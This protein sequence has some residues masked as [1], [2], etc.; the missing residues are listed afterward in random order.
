[1][2]DNTA[3]NEIMR[4][5]VQDAEANYREQTWNDRPL[6]TL[7]DHFPNGAV[8]LFDPELRFLVAGGQGLAEAGLPPHFLEGKTVW[9]AFDPA[10]AA[11]NDPLMRA[12]LEGRASTSEVSY[13]ERVYEL[14]VL[15]IRNDEGVVV[16][17]MTLTQDITARKKDESQQRFLARAAELLTSSLDYQTTLQSVAQLVVPH[18]ADWCVVHLLNENGELEL[19]TAAHVDPARVE[20]ALASSRRY[21]PRMDQ[22]GG[23]AGVARTGQSAWHENITDDMFRAAAQDEEH[24]RLLA[25]SGMTSYLCVPLKARGKI[26]GTITF[27]GAESGHRYTQD[28]LPLAEELA[29]YAAVAVDNA[30]LFEQAQQQ[31][32]AREQAQNA[33]RDSEKQLRLVMD[34]APILISYIDLQQRYRFNNKTYADWLKQSP[35]LINGKHV[36]DVIGQAAYEAVREQ[37]EAALRGEPVVY[38]REMRYQGVMPRYVH[39]EFVPDRN[40]RGDVQGF[41]AVVSDI[42]DIKR[43][44]DALAES[45]RRYRFMADSIPQIVWTASAD[46]GVDYYNQR[47]TEYTGLTLAQTGDW[48]WRACQHPDDLQPTLNAWARAL[49]TGVEYKIEHRVRGKD[50]KYHWFLTRGV[51]M[52]DAD[53]N[54]LKWFGTM[55]DIDEQKR[56]EARERMLGE[57]GEQMRATNDPQEVM[58]RAVC[59]IG[60]FLQTSR[61]YYAE[62]NGDTTTIHRDHCRNVAS[63]AGTYKRNDFGGEIIQDLSRGRTVSITDTLTDPRTS[64]HYATMYAPVNIR[65]YLAVPLMEGGRQAATLVVSSSHTP[66]AWTAEETSLLETVAARTRMA[67]EN[68]RLW[69]AERERSEQLARAIQEVHHRVKNSLQGV[70]AL[71]EMQLPFDSDVLPVSTVRE[72]LNQIKTIALVHD[73]LARDQPIGDVDAAQVLTKL[74]DLLAASMR[75][76]QNPVPIYVEAEQVWIPTKAA[77]SLALVVNELVSNAVKHTPKFDLALPGQAGSGGSAGRAPIIEVCLAKRDGHVHVVVQDSGPGFPAGFDPLRDA[78]IGLELVVTL[79]RHDLHGTVTF[80]SSG[81]HDAE[82]GAHGGRVEIIFPEAVPSE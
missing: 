40:E 74:G 16:A 43:Q 10:V 3:N 24:Y 34:A 31:V 70:S 27:T 57:L 37:I 79:V 9:E 45:E 67:V 59:M 11:L 35:E 42:T 7:I 73:L 80:M 75:T 71:L 76:A 78:N 55:T 12:A 48:A 72:G 29:R 53:D 19:V 64:A 23:V 20:A 46:G 17:G 44:Q 68:A 81:R 38:E 54:I 26:L 65:A 63:W 49:Q 41:V 1:M 52:R 58:W 8:V 66:R 60:E 14:R 36:S 82:N 51:A 5:K 47:W 21:P 6:R 18:L 33:L 25:A 62:V 13:G 15:P 30:R 2:P 39:S 4:D 61:C 50:G 56:A 32:V 28:S 22:A 69:Q 77:T